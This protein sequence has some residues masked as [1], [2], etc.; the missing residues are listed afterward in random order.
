M[1]R[2]ILLA[3]IKKGAIQVQTEDFK[4]EIQAILKGSAS[5]NMAYIGVS[6]GLFECLNS[7]GPVTLLELCRSA[8]TD[9]GYT[10]RWCDAAYAFELITEKDGKFTLSQKGRCFLKE[11]KDSL[12][13]MPVQAVIG[14][15]MAERAAGLIKTGEIVGEKILG[16]RPTVLPLFGFMLEKSFAPLFENTIL[17]RL[18]IYKNINEK[19]GTVIDLG[20]GNG[21][22]IRRILAAYDG[23]RGIGIDGFEE[24]IRLAGELAKKENLKERI[25]FQSGDIFEYNPKEKVHGIAMNR[26]LHHVWDR[27]ELVFQKFSDFLV[28][29]GAAVIWEPRWPDKRSDLL[30]PSRQMMAVQNLG[31]HA[32]GNHFLRPEEIEE[33]FAK[34]GM[35]AT[36]LLFMDGNES[37]VVGIKN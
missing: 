9:P 36:T 33:Q 7:S 22:Y 34:V 24:N 37:V 16:E 12:A 2:C 32:Q 10:E 35:K 27:K 8:G 25:E 23:I 14:T 19:K 3:G 28:P 31:E 6:S 26:A 5:L 17:P 30:H 18:E 4:K 15:H 13:A 21:W 1:T 29:G 11:G 20:C